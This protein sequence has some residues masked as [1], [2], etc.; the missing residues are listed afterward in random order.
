MNNK[1]AYVL[2]IKNFLGQFSNVYCIFWVKAHAGNIGNEIADQ[3]AKDVVRS[4][5]KYSDSTIF[6]C[7]VH[8]CLF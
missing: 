7:P 3:L 2:E 6:S 8:Y 1:F 5:F 4:P